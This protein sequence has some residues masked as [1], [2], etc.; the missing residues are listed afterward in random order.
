MVIAA[1]ILLRLVKINLKTSEQ[2][3]CQVNFSVSLRQTF[4]SPIGCYTMLGNNIPKM[5][6]P[7]DEKAVPKYSAIFNGEQH[8]AVRF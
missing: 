3:D 6:S 4:C 7:E 8:V 1:Q 2:F 5:L